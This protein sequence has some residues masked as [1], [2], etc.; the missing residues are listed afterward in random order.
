MVSIGY[1]VCLD[2]KNQLTQFIQITFRSSHSWKARSSNLDKHNVKV[3]LKKTNA[4]YHLSLTFP[5][6]DYGNAI[7]EVVIIVIV[8]II[9]AIRQKHHHTGYFSQALLLVQDRKVK[10]KEKNMHRQMSVNRDGLKSRQQEKHPRSI[11][12]GSIL[13]FFLGGGHNRYEERSDHP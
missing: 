8:I 2:T 9:K 3:N 5:L 7:Q 11:Q 10:E 4:C 12:K 13:L 6:E 1:N